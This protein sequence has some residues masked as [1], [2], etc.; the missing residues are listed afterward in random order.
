MHVTIVRVKLDFRKI[1]LCTQVLH[2]PWQQ[3]HH[4]SA[5]NAPFLLQTCNRTI[6]NHMCDA[7]F[8]IFFMRMTVVSDAKIA[9]YRKVH[10]NVQRKV[11]N[12]DC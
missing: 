3:L 12:E 4:T 1:F 10:A 5:A 2:H 9:Y 7:R 11:D 6:I 8:P